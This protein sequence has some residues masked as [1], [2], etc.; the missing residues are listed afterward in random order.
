MA[1]IEAFLL[2]CKKVLREVSLHVI[3]FIVIQI[4]NQDSLKEILLEDSE[5]RRS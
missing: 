2:S 4:R 1:Q 3:L 5:W